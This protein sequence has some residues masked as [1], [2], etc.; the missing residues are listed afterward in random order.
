MSR[1]YL[2]CWVLPTIASQTFDS[3]GIDSRR[4]NTGIWKISMIEV[5]ETEIIDLCQGPDRYTCLKYYQ[6]KL[7]SYPFTLQSKNVHKSLLSIMRLWN[8][9]QNSSFLDVWTKMSVCRYLFNFRV[10]LSC[11]QRN[12]LLV[13]YLKLH[14]GIWHIKK[15][16][17]QVVVRL[18]DLNPA[19]WKVGTQVIKT[20]TDLSLQ[21]GIGKCF[22]GHNL[23]NHKLKINRLLAPKSSISIKN[24]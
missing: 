11:L 23:K 9:Y 14:I 13:P 12:L 18:F 5:F 17:Q 24:P 16:A 2:F 22:L 7:K 8:F 21:K 4:P 10:S 3:G 20:D 1:F 15:M 6:F 19:Y